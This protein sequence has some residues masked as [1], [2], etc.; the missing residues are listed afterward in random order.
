MFLGIVF[1]F[2]SNNV[3]LMFEGVCMF[4]ILVLEYYYLDMVRFLW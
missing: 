2:F 4:M 3:I 1:F